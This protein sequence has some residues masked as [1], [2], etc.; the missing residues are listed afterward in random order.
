[1]RPRCPRWGRVGWH[2]GGGRRLA[3][4]KGEG[5]RGTP[6]RCSYILRLRRFRNLRD[7]RITIAAVAQL[8]KYHTQRPSI[9]VICAVIRS[10][11]AAQHADRRLCVRRLWPPRRSEVDIP[12]I[13]LREVEE[14][15]DE[16]AAL[17]ILER[18]VKDGRTVGECAEQRKGCHADLRR[19]C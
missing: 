15:G 18:G 13:G 14:Q 10:K 1:M 2:G 7:L 3:P 11:R 8:T 12:C 4:S 16:Q 6:F 17:R 19:S 9:R 5:K